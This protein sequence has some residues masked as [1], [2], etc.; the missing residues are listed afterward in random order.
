MKPVLTCE[1]CVH[2]MSDLNGRIA[3]KAFPLGIPIELF[4]GARDHDRP[5]PGD[6]GYRYTADR[7]LPSRRLPELSGC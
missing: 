1:N 5:Y 6:M 2:F 4:A 7:A 3:C